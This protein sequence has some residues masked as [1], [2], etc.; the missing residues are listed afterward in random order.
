MNR[1]YKSIWS[2]AQGAWVAVSEV[3]GGRGKK[4]RGG[5]A[6][7]TGLAIGAALMGAP[8]LAGAQQTFGAAR[9]PVPSAVIELV[10]PTAVGS[11]RG[12]LNARVALTGYNDQASFNGGTPA[13]GLT[14]YNTATNGGMTP[15]LYTWNGSQWI[16]NSQ[17]QYVHSNSTAVGNSTAAT[18]GATGPESVAIGPLAVAA[19]ASSVAIGNGAQA[20]GI[21][22]ISIGTGN[23]VSGDNSG[24]FGDPTVVSGTG[25]YSFGNNNT[26]AANNAFVLGNNVTI[27]AGL[28]GAVGIGNDSTVAASTVA[29]YNPG[30]GTVSGTAIGSNVVSVGS[31]GGE[32]R[33]TNV[34]AGGADTDAVNVSQL[35]AVSAAASAIDFPIRS[36][37]AGPYATS[38]TGVNSLA[39]GASATAGAAGATALGEGANAN[40]TDSIAIGRN[41][42]VKTIVTPRTVAGDIAIG[43]DSVAANYGFSSSGSVY[44]S[45]VAV[46]SKANAAGSGA[47]A[48]GGNTFATNGSVAV[49]AGAIAGATPFG[50][51]QATNLSQIAIGSGARAGAN[52]TDFGG[53]NSI[54]IGNQAVASV[55]DE[56]D[57]IAIGNVARAAA[58]DTIALGT[59]SNANAGG[60]LAFGRFASA[61]TAGA[62]AIG[63][64][65]IANASVDDVAL[66]SGSVTAAPNPTNSATVNGHTYGPFAG[67]APT[68]V[69]S[70]GTGVAGGE[71]QITNVGAGRITALSTDA[72][73]GSQLYAVA[74]ALTSTVAAG[75][76]HYYS[77]NSA[78]QTAGSNYANDGATGTNALAAGVGALA[79]GGQTTAIGNGA[80][81]AVAGGVALG[82]ASVSDRALVP[83]T[84]ILAAGNFMVPYNTTDRTLLGAVSVGN[85]TS[86]RQ[87]TNVADG[88]QS[89]DAVTVRQLT[90]ALQSFA[91]TPT[92]YFHANSVAADSLAVGSESVAVGPQTV[93][94]G[95][96]AIGIGNGAT[97]QISAPG[98][99]AIGQGAN[100]QLADSI[101]MGTNASAAAVQG[102]A[103]G[104]GSIVNVA[105]GVALGAG[106][107]A[108]TAA[109]AKGYVP[110]GASVAQT[111]AVNATT[112]TLAG[113]SVGNAA[114]GQL[115]QINGVAAGSVDSDAVNVSQLK[116]VQ[117]SVTTLDNNAVKYDTTT[118]GTTNYNSVNLGNSNS[119]GPVTLGNVANGVAPNDAVNVQQL[120]AGVASANAYT[121]ARVN[122]LQGNIDGVARKAYAGV[123]SAMAL[124]SA[125]YIAGKTTYAAGMGYYQS[126]GAVGIALR[127]TADN[128]RWSVTGG[129]SASAGGVAVRA[130]VSGIWE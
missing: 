121:D 46:G 12:L 4:S 39:V 107:I 41:A 80:N 16:S 47:V 109:G 89:Q 29:S 62:I 128:G 116:A 119:T 111:A 2:E 22:S 115:R 87:I 113:V 44:V 66:G 40:R 11:A 118:A 70:V 24:A 77:V 19:G 63:Y 64:G 33:V 90:G 84:G 72:I 1:S 104:A 103:L 17:A 127:R 106:S 55:A 3:A 25:S 83:S 13:N 51:A 65:S 31:V 38:A 48:V 95:N 68:S 56:H 82:S 18:S 110:T 45:A 30:T 57:T 43:A 71:R 67:S 32:R 35:K 122:G 96:N 9:A 114:S 20:T 100:T 108:S 28:D 21:S 58:A 6:V 124:E 129:V 101:A 91:V 54:A 74:D 120:N 92:K 99:I 98:S 105:G 50:T 88:T 93:V 94:N 59:F 112:S 102:I 8:L 86:Y 85:A 126:Q 34:A 37:N 117:T 5:A 53:T 78:D 130:G 123:A 81:A 23:K 15:G 26:I 42:R 7:L 14:V 97:V 69:V 27:A 49:G 61:Q 76:T 79:S 73:N 60:A 75:A 36:G 52:T 125:P 10:S